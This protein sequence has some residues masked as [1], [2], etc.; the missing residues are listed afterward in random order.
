MFSWLIRL[1]WLWTYLRVSILTNVHYISLV[2]NT[3]RTAVALKANLINRFWA[4]VT[5]GNVLH[6]SSWY[7][8]ATVMLDKFYV[9][10]WIWLVF[11]GA[12]FLLYHSDLIQFFWRVTLWAFL[13]FYFHV[14][15]WTCWLIYPWV[16]VTI[17]GVC[18]VYV[19]N[20]IQR[21]GLIR[22]LRIVWFWNVLNLLLFHCMI[23]VLPLNFM[24]YPIWS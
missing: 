13:T 11:L 9:V 5:D 12:G 14:L 19:E 21:K 24:P 17:E 8:K 2:W 16:V 15:I 10:T 7:D 1:I 4:K 20:S 6:I 18:S 22:S 3:F 23:H